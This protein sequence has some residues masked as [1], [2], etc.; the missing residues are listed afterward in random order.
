MNVEIRETIVTAKHDKD[1]V[2]LHISDAPPGDESAEIVLR[3]TVPIPR[4]PA[5]L[6]AHVQ[7]EA[8]EVASKVLSNHLQALAQQIGNAGRDL[9]PNRMESW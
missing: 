6:L 5:P 9:D 4:S 2:Q 8:I 3:L 7:R 1:V